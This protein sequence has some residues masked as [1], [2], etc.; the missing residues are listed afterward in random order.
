MAFVLNQPAEKATPQARWALMKLSSLL[1]LRFLY[2][3]D[4]LEELQALVMT[5]EIEP[6]TWTL[7]YGMSRSDFGSAWNDD[8]QAKQRLR[9]LAEAE[10]GKD[11]FLFY[12]KKKV[13]RSLFRVVWIDSRGRPIPPCTRKE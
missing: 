7:K 8:Y 9:V 3:F 2:R 12:K 4:Y 10:F 5:I 6:G 13:P 11:L 1:G